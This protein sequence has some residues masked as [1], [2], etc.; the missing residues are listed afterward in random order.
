MHQ[1][2]GVPDPRPP[3]ARQPVSR[4]QP[5]LDVGDHTL[6][7]RGPDHVREA[8]EHESVPLSPFRRAHRRG[9]RCPR[10]GAARP[11]RRP[12]RRRPGP[13]GVAPVDRTR[14]ASRLHRD[15]TPPSAAT[16]V[17]T[18]DPAGDPS[19]RPSRGSDRIAAAVA[20]SVAP[21]PHAQAAAWARGSAGRAGGRPPR[22][23]PRAARRRRPP[24]P[25]AGRPP[26]SR[27]PSRGQVRARRGSSRR[28]WRLSRRDGAAG[29]R[30]S[31]CSTAYRAACVR[32]RGRACPRRCSR[33]SSRSS[34]R[35]PSPPRSSRLARPRAEQPEDLE[36][37]AV[38]GIPPAGRCGPGEAARP[39]AAPPRG[40][41]HPSVARVA[42]SPR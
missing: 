37:R 25:A 4:S 24:P 34:P 14:R 40:P 2:R 23:R 36:L 3:P 17:T 6:G 9:A 22:L 7:V 20:G 41:A 42:A 39:G 32:S 10:R 35:R 31:P 8:V 26:G 13:P 19:R 29:S 21:A 18:S 30:T 1:E 11:A 27:D 12:R 38:R 16:P 5:A 28:A 15:R 33:A